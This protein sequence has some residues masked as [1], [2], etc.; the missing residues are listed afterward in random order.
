PA[1][2]MNESELLSVVPDQAAFAAARCPL[3]AARCPLPAARCP[4][5]GDPVAATTRPPQRRGAAESEHF[6]GRPI[7]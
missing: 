2:R 6:R 7:R 1:P 5:P 4:L 3:P